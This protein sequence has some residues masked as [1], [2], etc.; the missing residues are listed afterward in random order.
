VGRTRRGCDAYSGGR[1][2]SFGLLWHIG[3]IVAV[4]LSGVVVGYYRKEK[5]ERNRKSKERN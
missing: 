5:N 3:A 2:M 4:F 1:I